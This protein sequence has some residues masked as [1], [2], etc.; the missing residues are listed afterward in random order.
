MEE[1]DSCVD[2]EPQTAPV[3]LTKL[4]AERE[5]NSA[6]TVGQA[7]S[8]IHQSDLNGHGGPVSYI[9]SGWYREV[10]A[11]EHGK[12][13]AL[14]KAPA[15]WQDF[16]AAVE[17]YS[18]KHPDVVAK[19]YRSRSEDSSRRLEERT[20]EAIP[21]GGRRMASPR[22]RVA[23][24]SSTIKAAAGRRAKTQETTSGRVHVTRLQD[25]PGAEFRAVGSG[26]MRQE[27][28]HG[29]SCRQGHG[30]LQVKWD[31]VHKLPPWS[32]EEG[33][34]ALSMRHFHRNRESDK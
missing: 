24:R 33:G 27:P 1:Q 5:S 3:R 4:L 34:D 28:A 29:W 10:T 8:Q 14:P 12:T 30:V 31:E 22:D 16:Y 26:W 19:Y 18:Q 17:A 2:Q 11:P 7:S 6:D 32:E 21:P 9:G 23:T 13:A 20:P 15:T 25:Y